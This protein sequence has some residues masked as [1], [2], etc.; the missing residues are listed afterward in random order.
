M[1]VNTRA[2]HAGEHALDHADEH[3]SEQEARHEREHHAVDDLHPLA[4]HHA[5]KAVHGDGAARDARDEGMGL[6]RGDAAPP[7]E[8]AP[9]NGADHRRH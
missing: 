2:V 4:Y 1:L 3:P 8:H 9:Y 7:A 6:G 5:G